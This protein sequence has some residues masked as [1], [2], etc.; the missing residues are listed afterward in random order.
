MGKATLYIMQ[1]FLGAGKTT[2][3]KQLSLELDAVHLNPDEWCMKLFDKK[4]YEQDWEN[5]FSETLDILW[6]KT[7]EYLN[8]GTDV[9]FDMGFW[10]RDSRN[11]AKSIAGQCGSDF[12]HYYIYAPDD[13]LKRRIST[14]PGKI[15]EN[16]VKNFEEIKKLF[17]EPE[18]DENPIIINSYQSV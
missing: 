14:R 15:A 18:I 11:H 17:Q 3:S 4:H 6:Q 16:N 1:G 5:C 7:V 2:F 10:S 9:I 12:K 8:N 13:V